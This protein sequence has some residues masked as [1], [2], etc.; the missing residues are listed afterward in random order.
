MRY[1]QVGRGYRGW[2]NAAETGMEA[3][4]RPMLIRF[5]QTAESS[6]FRM[7]TACQQL[8]QRWEKLLH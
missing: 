6:C 5:D 1:K 8:L 3:V 2:L 7:F 4:C